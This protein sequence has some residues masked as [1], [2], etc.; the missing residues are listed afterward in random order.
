MKNNCTQ[1]AVWQ[2]GGRGSS[3]S[4]CGFSSFGS[5]AGFSEPRHFAKP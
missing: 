4:L 5:R 3:E 2:N 1:L